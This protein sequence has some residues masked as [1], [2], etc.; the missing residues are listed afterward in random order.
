MVTKESADK[1]SNLINKVENSGAKAES[2]GYG[3][4]NFK[5][6]LTDHKT[7]HND[8][9]KAHACSIKDRRKSMPAVR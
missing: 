4:S 8:T 9:P 6:N 7:E 5:Q 2:F 1:R 3:K